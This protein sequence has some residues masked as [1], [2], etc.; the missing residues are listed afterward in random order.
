MLNRSET[1]EQYR[2]ILSVYDMDRISREKV[3]NGAKGIKIYDMNDSLI[4]SKQFVIFNRCSK[5]H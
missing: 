1:M 3:T 2:Y 4:S 5:L